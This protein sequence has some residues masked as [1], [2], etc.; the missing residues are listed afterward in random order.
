VG[1]TQFG[2]PNHQIE[3]AFTIINNNTDYLT[4]TGIHAHTGSQLL[5][6]ASLVDTIKHTFEIALHIEKEYR[7]VITKI[8][9]GG[10]WGID[11]FEGQTP[12][13]LDR[14]SNDIQQLKSNPLY[15]SII[16]RSNLKIEPGRFLTGEC[17]LYAV[18]I[19]NLKRI[20]KFTF[21]IT[22]GGMHQNYILAGGMGQVIQRNFEFDVISKY[23]HKPCSEYRLTITGKL[24]TPNDILIRDTPFSKTLNIGDYIV[25]FN[26][27]AYGLSA[28][29][30][31]F[32][33]HEKPAEIIV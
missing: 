21:A 13:D 10:G 5:D 18:E 22:N 8:N 29:P 12:F 31:N 27:G 19:V 16:E 2:I 1:G 32:L 17:G 4:F 11:Y 25:F 15:R 28:S 24:C 3:Q 7:T 20:D 6:E 33:S 9:F 23:Q 26:C 30:V 14:I